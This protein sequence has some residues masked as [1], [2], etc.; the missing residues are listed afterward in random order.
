MLAG[1]SERW[2]DHRA[3]RR[4]S[5]RRHAVQPRCGSQVR[6]LRRPTAS[7]PSFVI[8]WVSQF[9]LYLRLSS[10]VISVLLVRCSF[11][12]GSVPTSFLPLFVCSFV[13]SFVS[14]FL[15]FCLCLFVCLFLPFFLS[16]FLSFF[17]SFFLYFFLP[18]FLSSF[19]PSFFP[20]FLSFFFYFLF[21]FFLSSFLPLPTFSTFPAFSFPLS[22][23]FLSLLFLLPPPL[24]ASDTWLTGER[25][26][27]GA[28]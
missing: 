9:P 22:R 8:T 19:L 23:A 21:L 16:S 4:H 6:H 7:L 10:I 1:R 18:F 14:S 27:E 28:H 25:D 5:R 26:S 2:R 24:R 12:L 11:Y 17:I 20:S 13:R 15:P 3:T